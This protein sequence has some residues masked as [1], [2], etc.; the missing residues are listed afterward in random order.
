[1]SPEEI[2]RRLATDPDFINTRRFNFS[3]AEM[4][5]RYPGGAPD[6]LIAAALDMTEGELEQRFA[7]I[8]AELRRVVGEA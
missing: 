4:R 3:L 7:R 2:R 1:M 6:H 5:E 8:V